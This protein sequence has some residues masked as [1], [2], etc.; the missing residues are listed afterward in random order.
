MQ[1]RSFPVKKLYTLG[2]IFSTRTHT[3]LHLCV[4]ILFTEKY[5]QDEVNCLLPSILL[6]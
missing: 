3:Y 5:M 1:K 2:N 4:C 6:G